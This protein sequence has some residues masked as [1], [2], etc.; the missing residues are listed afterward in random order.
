MLRLL[1]D[2]GQFARCSSSSG[3]R[4]VITGRSFDVAGHRQPAHDEVGR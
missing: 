1:G 2:L 4:N 3:P